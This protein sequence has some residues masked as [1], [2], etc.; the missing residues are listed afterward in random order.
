MN[1]LVQFAPWIAF[2]LVSEIDW[3]LGLA[4][5]LICQIALILAVHP[6]RVGVLNGAM[7][8]FFVVLG[9][10]ALVR[11]DSPIQDHVSTI[12]TGFLALV[13]AASLVVGHPFTLDFSRDRVPASVAKSE[14]FMAVNRT[15]TGVW[16]ACFAGIAAAGV[17]AAATDRPTL[18]TVATIV[19]LV[20]AVHFTIRYPQQAR[21]R[22]LTEAEAA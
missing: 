7:L 8:G 20:L 15:I 17:L 10:F 2:S 4:V 9:V 6:R 13:A 11:P 1:M 16:A 14:R 21:E 3:R 22:A 12:S 19:L 5:G 18:D